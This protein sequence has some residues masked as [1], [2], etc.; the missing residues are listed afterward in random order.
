MCSLAPCY[1]QTLQQ[2]LPTG[3]R[4]YRTHTYVQQ[5]EFV[6]TLCP[7]QTLDLL[8]VYHCCGTHLRILRVQFT[9]IHIDE[10][11]LESR[12]I[13]S[14]D[15]P[16]INAA[17][18][19]C[20]MAHWCRSCSCQQNNFFVSLTINNTGYRVEGS[21]TLDRASTRITCGI[22]PE[23]IYPFC[24]WGVVT[25]TTVSVAQ[26][27]CLLLHL[28]I[29]SQR[30]PPP[31]ARTSGKRELSMSPQDAHL[32]SND[33]YVLY[34]VICCFLNSV[35]LPWTWTVP[36]RETARYSAHFCSSGNARSKDGLLHCTK[37]ICFLDRCSC[38]C[39]C[40]CR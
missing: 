33:C 11:A 35:M 9:Y 6:V 16:F 23:V 32:L 4:L 20:A 25:I 28:L 13:G 21:D 2:Q 18:C 10:N 14:F 3:T 39:C 27:R 1:S 7:A 31:Q 5:R 26:N 30:F 34:S 36:G 40:C 24:E 12:P 17:C 29:V 22:D 38:R 37:G 15:G 8:V 19:S